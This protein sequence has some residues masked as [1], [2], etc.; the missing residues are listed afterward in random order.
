VSAFS[1]VAKA[2]NTLI[3]PSNLSD[4]A[5]LVAS[6]MTVLDRTRPG[7]VSPPAPRA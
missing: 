6:A 7:A 5:G 1:N 2:A 4:V 3:L